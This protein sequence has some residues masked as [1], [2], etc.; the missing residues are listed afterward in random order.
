MSILVYGAIICV[1]VYILYYFNK[2]ETRLSYFDLLIL[3]LAN[4]RLTRL[5]VYDLVMNFARDYL[6]KSNRLE[7]KTL[8]EIISCPWC[9][10]IWIAPILG[11][12][13][14]ITPLAYFPIFFIA[15]AGAGSILQTISTYISKSSSPEKHLSE[16]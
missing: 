13:Y 4:F 2:I 12:L 14:V 9:T 11:F 8:F 15:L 7:G 10:G 3:G 16:T 5:F 1:S 6:K